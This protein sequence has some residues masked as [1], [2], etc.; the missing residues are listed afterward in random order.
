MHR[1]RKHLIGDAAAVAICLA[2]IVGCGTI[3]SEGRGGHTVVSRRVQVLPTYRARG[4]GFQV[5]R[6]PQ[7]LT[8]PW[9]YDNLAR[10]HRDYTVS[11]YEKLSAYGKQL[12]PLPWYIREESPSTEAAVVV[13]PGDSATMPSYA[14]PES[15]VLYFFEGGAYGA[16]GLQ[17]VPGDV[18]IGGSASG[19]VEP[20]FHAGEIEAQNDTYDFSGGGTKLALSAL[21]GSITITTTRPIAGFVNEVTFPDGSHDGIVRQAGT[22]IK[23]SSPLS[24]PEAAGTPLWSSRAGPLGYLSLASPQA[25]E[26]IRTNA[27]S[28]P[29]MRWEMLDIGASG[30]GIEDAQVA[31][32]SG[33]ERDGYNLVLAQPL[34]SAVSAGAPV[35]YAGPASDVTVEYL[36]IGNGGG[37]HTLMVGSG[38]TIEHNDIHDNYAGGANYL[39][40]SAAGQAIIGADNSTI[41][42]NCFQRLG[43]YALN[44]GGANTRFD[45]NQVDETP[46]QPDLSGNGQSGCGKWWASFNNDVVDN[47]FTDEGYSVCIWFDNGNTGMLV[48]GNYFY[49]IAN[50]AIQNETGYNSKYT[51]NL[52]KDVTGGLYLNDSGGW[53][54][55]GSRFNKEVVVEGNTFDN[56]QQAIDIWGASGRNCLNSGEAAPNGESDP[57][58]S[59]G[60]PYAQGG[61]AEYFSHYQD[62]VVG[63]VATVVN[64]QVCSSGSP[65]STVTLSNGVPVDDWVGF[66]GQA[67]DN[68]TSGGCGGYGNDPVMT[69]TGDTTNV[70]SF[71]GSGTINVSSTTGFPSSGQLLLST[72]GGT[73]Y[74][75]TGAVVSYTGTTATSFTGVDLVSGSGTLKGGVVAVQPYHVTGV[76]CPGGTCTNNAVVSVSPPITTNLAAGAEV[77]AT[78][79]CPY[80]VTSTATPG[81]ALAPNGTSYYDGCMWEDRN[82]SVQGN[83]FEVNASQFASTPLPEGAGPGDWT[84]TTGPS[85]NCAQ[86]SMGYQYPGGN[87]APYNNVTLSNA[88]MSDS[89]LSGPL[90]NLN[91]SGSPLA[92]GSGGDVAPNADPAYNN[93]WSGNT[94]DGDWTFQAYT[95]AAGCPVSWSGSALAW[96]NGGG[97]ACSGLS[98]SQWQQYWGQN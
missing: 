29:I 54:I 10:G 3:T 65:C 67:P 51:D 86:N 73:L 95:N 87:A 9:T 4:E 53:D 39:S 22:T 50:R 37:N 77:Y 74:D 61:E 30:G 83:T 88:M 41:E 6:N 48:Q 98:L 46:Y 57:Y 62:S 85:G 52:F 90:A 63:G 66:A 18:V 7:R 84:C 38:W 44:G 33:S 75:S 91:A 71:T 72:S 40:T 1:A 27:T 20:V 31:H 92:T 68:C 35:Y 94:Y 79:T 96:V 15:P 36:N 47:A 80:Y 89:S 70:S 82:I 26:V 25:D 76:S 14:L 56:A 64:N 45:Y 24:G 5:C 19:Y 59:G 17:T 12:P 13:A 78:G 49:N 32:V 97:N 2:G 58:C 60:F 34:T 16:I 23:L 43:E 28:A 55:P 93:L 11:Q 42:Y 81:S 69:S 21:A 8:S